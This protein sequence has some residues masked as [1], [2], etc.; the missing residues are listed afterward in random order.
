MPMCTCLQSVSQP[1]AGAGLVIGL[2][3]G[4]FALVVVQPAGRQA[5]SGQSAMTFTREPVPQEI[6]S[7]PSSYLETSTKMHAVRVLAS[8]SSR[9]HSEPAFG[10]GTEAQRPRPGMRNAWKMDQP[11]EGVRVATVFPRDGWTM[12]P[13]APPHAWHPSA[14]RSR[15]A[16]LARYMS[17]RSSQTSIDLQY[18]LPRNVRPTTSWEARATMA[19]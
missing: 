5:T 3:L 9:I 14:G 11:R 18:G 2:F 7:N 15:P 10:F 1:L 4:C 12:P 8:P 16:D 6:R 19:G 13:A 17:R